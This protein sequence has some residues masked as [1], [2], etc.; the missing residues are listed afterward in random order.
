MIRPSTDGFVT[1]RP[2]ELED[3]RAIAEVCRADPDILHWVMRVGN[4]V[5]EGAAKWITERQNREQSGEQITRAIVSTENSLFLGSAWLGRFDHE[6]RRAEIAFWTAVEARNKGVAT[7]AVRFMTTFAFEDLGLLRVE[8]LVSVE[9]GASQ[10]VAEKAGF[11]REGV[12]RSYRNIAGEQT[13][14]VIYSRLESDP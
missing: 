2:L 6:A 12:L 7:E 5:E 8:I 10:R 13:D 4:P 1:L 11:A 14:L 9:N 3:A